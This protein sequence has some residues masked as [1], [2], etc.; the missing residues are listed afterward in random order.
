MYIYRHI[1]LSSAKNS[2]ASAQE[3]KSTLVT[4][5][6]NSSNGSPLIAFHLNNE[7]APGRTE[8]NPRKIH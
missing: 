7:Y 6:K 3:G 1:T 5:L 2:L 4:F 8:L